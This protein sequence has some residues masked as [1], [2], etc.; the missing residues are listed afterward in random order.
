MGEKGQEQK[1]SQDGMRFTQSRV[2]LRPF[3]EKDDHA[4]RISI[5]KGRRGGTLSSESFLKYI[6][7]TGKAAV[8]VPAM[9]NDSEHILEAVLPENRLAI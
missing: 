6:R 4:F 1:I 3:K 5:P 2:E 7:R 8:S 9:W